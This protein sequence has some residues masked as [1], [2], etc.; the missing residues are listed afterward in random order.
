MLICHLFIFAMQ[1]LSIQATGSPFH[2]LKVNDR[3]GFHNL[4]R[5]P[6]HY[7]GHI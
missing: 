1:P 7:S 6:K 2:F 3:T 5:Y 4:G